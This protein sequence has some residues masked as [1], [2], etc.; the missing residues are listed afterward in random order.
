MGRM[1]G[2]MRTRRAKRFLT[3]WP[4]RAAPV[5]LLAISL[6][7]LPMMAAD[8][9]PTGTL[10]AVFLGTN[11]V[12]G[13]VDP[14]TGA[15]TGPVADLTEELARRLGVPFKVIPAADGRAVIDMLTSHSADIGFLAYDETRAREVDF[16]NSYALMYSAYLVR[17]DSP[18]RKSSD[19]D[20][21]GLRIGA[22]R[23]ASQ[24]LYLSRNLKNAKVTM[25][26][27]TP[28]AGA[29]EKMLTDGELDAFG[30]N[31]QRVVDAAAQSVKLRALPDNFYANEQAVIVEKGDRSKVEAINRFL[32]DVRASGF[33]K[34]SL[35]RAKLS[36]VDVAPGK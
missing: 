25:F 33:V 24:E 15:V 10:R 12:Q 34:A 17:A 22:V 23:A 1:P 27:T 21:A 36:G 31:R 26:E 8:L 2:R 19:A 35:D 4:V 3:G 6:A 11:P 28:S 14:Q 7:A 29:L 16:C 9:A 5:A 18:I 13:K 20:R 30:A 32:D